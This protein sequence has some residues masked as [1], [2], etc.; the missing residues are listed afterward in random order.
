MPHT[1]LI[2]A[3]ASQGFGQGHTLR[4][5]NLTDAVRAAAPDTS[6]VW[7]ATEETFALVPSLRAAFSTVTLPDAPQ[8]QQMQAL[9]QAIGPQGAERPTLVTDGYHLDHQTP[10]A[11]REHGVAGKT[12]FIDEKVNRNLGT[13]DYVVDFLPHDA[14]CYDGVAGKTTELLLGPSYAMVSARFSALARQRHQWLNARKATTSKEVVMMNGGF[15][16]GD[17]LGDLADGIARKAPS[18]RDT[19][20]T[21]FA[22]SKAD[23]Y[24]P[25]ARRVQAARALGANITLVPDC[26]DIPARLAM[27]DLFMGAAGMTPFELGAVGGVASILFAAGH[28]QMETAQLIH[29]SGAGLH[30]G[31]FLQVVDGALERDARWGQARVDHA[32]DMARVLLNH[33]GSLR[34]YGER[35][36]LFCDGRGADRVARAIL[37]PKI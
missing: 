23:T 35:S 1:L 2:R 25:L 34:L 12:L 32:L 18:W 16:I 33:P 19:H 4:N 21:L 37:A 7:A 6:I 22:L 11:A 8:A 14:A 13:P 10:D 5:R 30:M 26:P 28:S 20:F 3:D 27:A 29:S 9:A 31:P 36:H 17:M 15:N 24:A